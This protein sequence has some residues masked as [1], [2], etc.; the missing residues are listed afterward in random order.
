MG[1]GGSILRRAVGMITAGVGDRSVDRAERYSA[2]IRSA[3][4]GLI[5]LRISVA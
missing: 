3:P 4:V 5:A 1:Q 2:A